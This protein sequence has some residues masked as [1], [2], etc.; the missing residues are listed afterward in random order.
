M[1]ACQGISV[2]MYSFCVGKGARPFQGGVR[3]R[4]NVMLPYQ[5]GCMSSQCLACKVSFVQFLRAAHT[6]PRVPMHGETLSS[7]RRA[8]V[9]RQPA[10]HTPIKRNVADQRGERR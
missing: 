3:R 5:G 7:E 9:S 8:H 1:G 2:P 6:S 10:S 4:G